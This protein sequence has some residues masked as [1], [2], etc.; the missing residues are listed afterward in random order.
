MNSLSF[1]AYCS[2]RAAESGESKKGKPAAMALKKM[3]SCTG[4]NIFP[5]IIALCRSVDLVYLHVKLRLPQEIQQNSLFVRC[6]HGVLCN[7]TFLKRDS[8]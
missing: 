2:T 6:M 4:G 1:P 7:K 8:I 3:I 5:V